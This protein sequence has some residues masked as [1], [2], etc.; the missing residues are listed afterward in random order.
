[1]TAKLVYLL[2]ALGSFSCALLLI[3]G[4]LSNRTKLLLWSSV[5]FVGL[6]VNNVFLFVDV[7]VFPDVDL[8]GTYWRNLIGAVSGGILLTGLIWEL[9]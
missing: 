3:R 9:T 1:M 7:I 2:C 8:F 5:C 4:Y 6:A